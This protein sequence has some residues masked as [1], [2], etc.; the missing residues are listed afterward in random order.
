[1]SLINKQEHQLQD[2]IDK[3]ILSKHPVPNNVYPVNMLDAYM[4]KA[5]RYH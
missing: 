4:V 5:I 1:M 3:N 2:Q